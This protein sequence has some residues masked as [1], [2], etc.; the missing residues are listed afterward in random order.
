MRLVRISSLAYSYRPLLI[1]M[2]NFRLKSDN[3]PKPSCPFP[4]Q[5]IAITSEPESQ[6]DQRHLV[7]GS[8]RRG[9][10]HWFFFSLGM[11]PMGWGGVRALDLELRLRCLSDWVSSPSCFSTIFS[12]S[13]M[14]IARINSCTVMS[15]SSAIFRSFV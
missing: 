8:V 13:G 3:D 6:F 9:M 5:R 14:T 4:R 7:S 15:L 1:K 2:P 10:D 11:T 12:Q